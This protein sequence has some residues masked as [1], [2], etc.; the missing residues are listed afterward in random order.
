MLW[1]VFPI[2]SLLEALC[3][4]E[5]TK[6]FHYRWNRSPYCIP[7]TVF[8][9]PP[10]PMPLSYYATLE[11]K[12]S[13]LPRFLMYLYHSATFTITYP[14]LSILLMSLPHYATF[15]IK[16]P[17]LPPFPLSLLHY[18]PFEI[19]Y[20]MFTELR[21]LWCNF[22]L[23]LCI[24]SN[25]PRPII[26]ITYKVYPRNIAFYLPSRVLRLI[27]VF[28]ITTE[29]T[30]RPQLM[31]RSDPFSNLILYTADL[32][33][34]TPLCLPLYPHSPSCRWWVRWSCPLGH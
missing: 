27:I 21:M 16:Y 10:F 34:R 6:I 11:I 18:T 32:I 28:Y 24:P 1:I 14:R 4:S 2:H 33:C 9:S 17:S 15:E 20:P 23:R 8:P 31:Q 3:E 5:S 7:N 30:S 13:H 25:A 29:E 26:T 12:Y 19:E 22:L